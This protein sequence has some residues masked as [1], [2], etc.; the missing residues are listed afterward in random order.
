[1]T[2]LQI[3]QSDF[4]PFSLNSKISRKPSWIF[5]TRIVKFQS[6][7][8]SKYGVGQR[9]RVCCG[10]QGGENQSKG[11]EPPE[12]LFMKELK[13][14]GMNP[15]SLVEDSKRT[16]YEVEEGVK[17]KEEDG[18]FSM[19][20]A[21]STDY[22]K[23]LSGQRERS[24]ML[25]SEGLEGLIPRAKVLLTIGGTFF[26]GFGPLI[27][28]TIAL[29]CALYLYFGPTFVHDGNDTPISLPQYIDPY[30]LLED[31]RISQIAPSVN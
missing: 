16:I 31:E 18:G 6:F 25:N 5:S 29:F 22:D 28:I 1:M 21:V 10:V 7:R 11:E 24:M 17:F 12:S 20:N 15:T 14:R 27:L 4:S 19:R 26:F 23:S 9:F 13:R 8:S 30:Q 3:L 2:S